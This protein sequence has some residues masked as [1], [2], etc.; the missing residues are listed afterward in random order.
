MIPNATL[1]SLG[2]SVD[3]KH[4]VYLLANSV[5]APCKSRGGRPEFPAPISPHGLCGRNATL[6]LNTVTTRRILHSDEQRCEPFQ[7]FS[8]VAMGMVTRRCP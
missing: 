3:V 5:K 2:V 1:I 8:D 7:R 6:N 4:R